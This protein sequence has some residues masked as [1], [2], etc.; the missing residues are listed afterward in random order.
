MG[1]GFF[2]TRGL[3]TGVQGLRGREMD[4]GDPIKRWR[5]PIRS[6][7]NFSRYKPRLA[8]EL[9]HD[10]RHM[11]FV[12]KLLKCLEAHSVFGGE[13]IAHRHVLVLVK[14]LERPN[15]MWARIHHH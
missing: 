5:C 6:C 1:K 15:I 3:R 13:S 4:L 7:Y 2:A 12:I 9:F 8:D 10:H 14:L 11:L